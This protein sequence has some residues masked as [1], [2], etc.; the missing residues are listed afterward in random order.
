[1]G[2]RVINILLVLLCLLVE[3][4][5]GLFGLLIGLIRNI[6]GGLASLVL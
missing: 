3:L 5:S 2:C 6:I 1:M 4:G